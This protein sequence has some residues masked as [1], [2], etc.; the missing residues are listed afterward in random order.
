MNFFTSSDTNSVNTY[1][2]TTIYPG[3]VTQGEGIDLRAEMNACLYGSNG[4]LPK[5]H[6]VIYRRYDRSTP[7]KFYNKQTREGVSGPAFKYTDELLRTRRVPI[8]FKGDSLTPLKV[9]QAIGDRY[10]YYLEYTVKPK[11]GDHI[12]ELNIDDQSTRPVI[13]KSILADRYILTAIHPYR[14]ENG[15]TQYFSI[16]AEYDEI[17]Y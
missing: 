2:N 6:W 11:R 14:L 3:I 15:N 10:I 1:I 12:I 9:G 17:S 4:T 13:S 16:Q 8:G 7:S 5:G